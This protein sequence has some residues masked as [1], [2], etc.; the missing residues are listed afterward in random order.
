MTYSN[1]Y[2]YQEKLNEVRAKY[3]LDENTYNYLV[4]V[5]LIKTLDKITQGMIYYRQGDMDMFEKLDIKEKFLALFMLGN[6]EL[7]NYL[8]NNNYQPFIDILNNKKVSEMLLD[9]MTMEMLLHANVAGVKY[10]IDLGGKISN[11]Y[12]LS[13]I[14]YN[15]VDSPDVLK[16][17]VENKK[18]NIRTNDY[19]LILLRSI[20]YNKFNKVKF[21][22]EN[23]TDIHIN[24]DEPLMTAIT[25]GHLDIVKVLVKNGADIHVDNDLPLINASGYGYLNIVKVLVE[26][27]ANVKAQNSKALEVALEQ[28]HEDVA[29]YLVSKGAKLY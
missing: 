18:I 29:N 24:N 17:L 6:K 19:S 8:P 4:Y 2:N 27:G 12:L 26:N 21:L 1:V 16:Y 28:D 11:I 5:N 15:F 3:N 22:V 23:G 14:N 7:I 13:R 20:T 10:F 25:Y 9:N